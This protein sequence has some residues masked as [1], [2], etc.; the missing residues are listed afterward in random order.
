[1]DQLTWAALN[2]IG[3]PKYA[4]NVQ[5][6]G[7]STYKEDVSH[8]TPI[9]KLSTTKTCVLNAIPDTESTTVQIIVSLKKSEL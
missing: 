9:A 8:K 4:N 7:F 5:S 3:M 1:M 6:D 2:G